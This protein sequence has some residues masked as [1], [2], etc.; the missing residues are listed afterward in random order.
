[1]KFISFRECF[2]CNLLQPRD[3]VIISRW[4]E[5]RRA[6]SPSENLVCGHD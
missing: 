5:R 4:A 2:H 1:M 6:R 3:S